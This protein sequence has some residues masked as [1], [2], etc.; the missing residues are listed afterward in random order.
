MRL[1]CCAVSLAVVA[2]V[3]AA[4]SDARPFVSLMRAT[5]PRLVLDAPVD[6]SIVRGFDPPRSDWGPGHR[7][8]DL[9]AAAHEPVTAAARG[10]VTFAGPV[11]SV[12]AVTVD[13]AGGVETTYSD[14]GSIAVSAGDVVARGARVGGAGSAHPTVSGVHFGVLVDGRYVDPERFLARD[15]AVRLVPVQGA[16]GARSPAPAAVAAALAAAARRVAGMAAAGAAGGPGRGKQEPPPPGGWAGN[17]GG[18][19]PGWGTGMRS[20]EGGTFVCGIDCGALSARS[21][22]PRRRRHRKSF[23]PKRQSGVQRGAPPRMSA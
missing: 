22:L 3:T 7:G 1:L 18:S 4:P 9:A 17:G 12:L 8:V 20:R 2:G 10:R 16:R 13:H 21:Q 5:R 11:A 14:L 6:G 19:S 23:V 15:A